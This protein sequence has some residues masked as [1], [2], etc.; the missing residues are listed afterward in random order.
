[1]TESGIDLFSPFAD[2]GSVGSGS[3][4]GPVPTK[5]VR[6]VDPA[7]PTRAEVAA[8]DRVSS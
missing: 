7:D 1:M 5:Q 6:V 3:L 2:T 8:V 4:G